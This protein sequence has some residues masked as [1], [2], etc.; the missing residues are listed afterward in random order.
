M[1]R[2]AKSRA[3]RSGVSLYDYLLSALDE[4]QEGVGLGVNITQ[5]QSNRTM[6]AYEIAPRGQGYSP[7]DVAE[8]IESLV[9]MFEDSKATLIARSIPTPTDDQVFQEMLARLVPCVEAISDYTNL[10]LRV[11]A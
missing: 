8:A 4:I 6:V 11:V 7:S 5:T 3:S 10:R 1:L 9:T 2:N